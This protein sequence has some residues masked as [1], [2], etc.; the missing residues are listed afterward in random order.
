MTDCG[1]SQNQTGCKLTRMEISL[2][3][4]PLV[5]RGSYITRG[6]AAK[7]VGEGYYVNIHC[8]TKTKV[9]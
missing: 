7:P 5:Q 4:L 1:K 3:D 8:N 2:D 6:N 9:R